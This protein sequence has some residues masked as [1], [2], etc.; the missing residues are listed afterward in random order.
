MNME[1][2]GPVVM[3]IMLL[4][5]VLVVGAGVHGARKSAREDDEQQRH[6]ME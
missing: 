1:I 4:A 5:F 3:Y 6:S 2:I